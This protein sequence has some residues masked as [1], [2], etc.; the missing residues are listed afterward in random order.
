MNAN[1]NRLS[2]KHLLVSAFLGLAAAG[3]TSYV[4]ALL[5]VIVAL[6]TTGRNATETPGLNAWHRVLVLPLSV[7]AGGLVFVMALRRKRTS[8]ASGV[9]KAEGGA[10][11]ATASGKAPNRSDKIS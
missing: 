2:G 8:S 3:A 11:L 4:I 7:L 9:A 10:A 5:G 1:S 6:F